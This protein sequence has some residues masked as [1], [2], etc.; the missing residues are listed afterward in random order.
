MGKST[1]S[2]AIFNCYVSSPEGIKNSGL[3]LQ[4]ADASLG[5]YRQELEV[6]HGIRE[7]IGVSTREDV[8]GSQDS[9]PVPVPNRLLQ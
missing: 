7:Q 8:P 1:I 5:G 9:W 6:G 2:M 4:Y 3:L